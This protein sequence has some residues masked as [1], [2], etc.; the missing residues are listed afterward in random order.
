M[1]SEVPTM[2]SQGDDSSASELAVKTG[3]KRC[4]VRRRSAAQNNA[5]LD[6]HSDKKRPRQ[7]ESRLGK[8]RRRNIVISSEEEEDKE[9]ELEWLN[10]GAVTV[11]CKRVC[12]NTHV[13]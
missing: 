7:L 6:A 9:E 12:E 1:K 2:I 8:R 11:D 10:R 5:S 4:E 3:M 13:T